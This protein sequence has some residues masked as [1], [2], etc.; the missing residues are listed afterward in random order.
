MMGASDERQADPTGA[1]G[2]GML[3]VARNRL[4]I[5]DDGELKMSQKQVVQVNVAEPLPNLSF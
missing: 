3:Q 1:H 5:Q 4:D 2:S